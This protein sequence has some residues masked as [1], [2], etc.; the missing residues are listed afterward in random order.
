MRTVTAAIIGSMLALTPAP[1]AAQ[2]RV[3][4]RLAQAT[5]LSCSFTLVTTV[6]WSGQAGI[7]RGETTSSTLAINF[8]KIV[9]NEG[10]AEIVG[11]RGGFEIIAQLA[12]GVLH[13]MQSS[14]EGALYLTSVFPSETQSGSFKAVHSRHEFTPVSIPGYT[15][16]PEQY[17]GAC[18][19]A[20]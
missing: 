13:L 8:D 11:D 18:K 15:S 20:N 19:P 1:A 5:A 17:Y 9:A 12:G 2:S 16:R 7:P 14:R 3:A 10:T 4:E 6:E